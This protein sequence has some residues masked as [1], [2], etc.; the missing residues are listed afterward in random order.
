M[1]W[2]DHA[3]HP[4]ARPVLHAANSGA[5]RRPGPTLAAVAVPD[6]GDAGLS[7]PAVPVRAARSG[8]RTRRPRGGP[9]G[10]L[11]GR[12]DRAVGDLQRAAHRHGLGVAAADRRP[13]GPDRPAGQAGGRDRPGH[14]VGLRM[15][16]LPG[17]RAGVRTRAGAE[18]DP[19]RRPL[20][21]QRRGRLARVLRA[22]GSSRDP[23]RDQRRFRRGDRRTRLR[24][25]G[26]RTARLARSTAP[27]GPGD[28]ATFL[29]SLLRD[30]RRRPPPMGIPVSGL[31]PALP[32]D[33]AAH[34]RPC[35]LGHLRDPVECID[36]LP[37]DRAGSDN[38]ACDRRGCARGAALGA[39]PR[40]AVAHPGHPPTA[41]AVERLS[42]SP[43]PAARAAARWPCGRRR[44]P[45]RCRERGPTSRAAAPTAARSRWHRRRSR[46]SARP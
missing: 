45:Q 6:R 10:R 14:L 32:T 36:A 39:G 4:G 13:A 17:R 9:A 41:P 25:P 43:G 34:P 38:S 22:I 19:V 20:Q 29:P 2:G 46:R 23:G 31:L 37:G 15:D 24:L 12:G 42:R 44:R 3:G 18:P 8:R 16:L 40:G 11:L 1:I 5:L 28:P 33:L 21:R 30:Q 27:G 35:R 7:R 26:A